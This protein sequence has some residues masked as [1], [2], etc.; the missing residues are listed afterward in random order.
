MKANHTPTPWETDPRSP[1]CFTKKHSCDISI[2]GRTAAGNPRYVGRVYGEGPLSPLTGERN[3]NAALIVHAVNLHAALVKT[4]QQITTHLDMADASGR[5][6][7]NIRVA[8]K[9][10]RAALSTL[11][12][13]GS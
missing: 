8:A 7:E 1:D 2:F 12:K 6:S 9:K 5:G 13:K 4:L 10:A 11:A 3:A